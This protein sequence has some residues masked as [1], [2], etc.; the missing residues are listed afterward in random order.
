M[1]IKGSGPLSMTEI[2]SEFGRGINL[3][4]YRGTPW[5][6]DNGGSGTFSSGALPYS[7]FYN[8]RAYPTTIP[9]EY[10]IVAGGG[11]G[12][13]N[14]GGGGGAGGYL[15]GPFIISLS[16]GTSYS[17]DVG[18]GGAGGGNGTNGDN[19]GNSSFFGFTAIGGGGGG[20]G[21]FNR[22]N[23]GGSGGGGGYRP[24][25]PGG[26]G[27]PGQ[28]NNGGQGNGFAYNA[29][30]GGGGGAGGQGFS[31]A[32]RGQP[33]AGGPGRQWLDG[34]WYAGGG[35]GAA[36]EG[37]GNGGIG[38][39]GATATSGTPNTGGGGGGNHGSGGS[40]IVIIRYAGSPRCTGG[41]ITSVGGYT[42]HRFTSSGNLS[43][44]TPGFITY[45]SPGN[46]IF[47]PPANFNVLGVMVWGGGGSSGAY[48]SGGTVA[49]GGSGGWFYHAYTNTKANL[50]LSGESVTVGS[51][52]NG[53]GYAGN[54]GTFSQFGNFI[55]GRGGHSGGGSYAGRVNSAVVTTSLRSNW[56]TIA[57]EQG[58]AG[59]AQPENTNGGGYASWD[60]MNTTYSGGGGAAAMNDPY[61]SGRP[62]TYDFY[63][64]KASALAAGS[65]LYNPP[66][67]TSSVGLP[68][69]FLSLAAG[70][71]G[72]IG[73]A[74][75]RNGGGSGSNG[76]F[77]AGGGSGP[78]FVNP[79]PGA[80]GAV[81]I[82][83]Y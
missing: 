65:S 20:W 3:N 36:D 54:P 47:V 71:F 78:A 67:S 44:I 13:G 79:N 30:S 59:G 63:G 45:D 34:N 19:G 27:T 53:G 56:F 2:N 37:S 55:Y 66:S 62:Y 32:T 50:I 39:G 11:G 6:L 74:S 22:G 69:S 5:Y 25:N 80:Q 51:G 57:S 83:W 82:Y 70:G 46:Y 7:E 81:H 77:P 1:T 42:Y 52:G 12:A 43:V 8:K 33:A 68:S 23:D 48:Y 76:K 35:A 38:G 75:S 21:Y 9:A 40:G 41:T 16:P 28:G 26:S 60:G 49:Y 15:S 4:T 18:G 64:G 24:S 17:V 61:H 29:Y 73:G 10:L 58:G 31:S 14:V 72:Q